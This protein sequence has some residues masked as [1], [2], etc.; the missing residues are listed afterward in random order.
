MPQGSKKRGVKSLIQSHFPSAQLPFIPGKSQEK[1]NSI[2]GFP[3]CRFKQTQM[4]NIRGKKF[5]GSSQNQ[6]LNL[7]GWVRKIPWR[8]KQ[9]L[10]PVFLPGKSHRQRSLV[11]YSPW[12][13]KELGTSEQLSTGTIYKVFTLYFSAFLYKGLGNLQIA[14]GKVLGMR[15]EALNLSKESGGKLGFSHSVMSDSSTA[16]TVAH[17]ALDVHRISHARILSGL[18]FPSPGHLPNPGIEPGSPLLQRFLPFEPP[19][20]PF[21]GKHRVL[22]N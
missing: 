15:Q 5:P 2:P 10:T 22:F 11:D 16:W 7:L 8:T 21:S 19:E 3:I 20:K 1:R 17:Q 12:G 6:N 18:P 4:G 13:C 14:W 9:Q